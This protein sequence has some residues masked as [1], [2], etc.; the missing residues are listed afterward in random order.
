M[1]L[2]GSAIDAGKAEKFIL[3]DPDVPFPPPPDTGDAPLPSQSPTTSK[4]YPKP[5]EHLPGDHGAAEGEATRPAFSSAQSDI[6]EATA[7]APTTSASESLAPAPDE[8]WFPGM[9]KLVSNSK[10]VFGAASVVVVF[11]VGMGAFFLWRRRKARQG[12]Y[13][14]LTDS[15]VPMNSI[16]RG[17]RTTG[18]R[19]LYDAFGAVSDDD[20]DFVDEETGLRQPLAENAA[21][22][23]SGFLDDDEPGTS[24][25][26]QPIYTDEPTVSDRQRELSSTVMH[27]GEQSESSSADESWEH[28]DPS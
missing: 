25:I 17:K 14:S 13:R 23:H 18:T 1:S 10:W 6:V 22:F 3:A 15:D 24:H 5:T 7:S 2:W 8:G 19:E 11:G 4:S 20:D 21:A 9:Y 26:P 16:E 27:P 12:Q 28:A